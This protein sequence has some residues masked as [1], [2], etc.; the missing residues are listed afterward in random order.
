M[1]RAYAPSKSGNGRKTIN[2][3]PPSE[4]QKETPVASPSVAWLMFILRLTNGNHG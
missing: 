2:A 1:D 4:F 3:S